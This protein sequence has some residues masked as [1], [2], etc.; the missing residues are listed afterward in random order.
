MGPN[1]CPCLLELISTFS[2]F[3]E[4]KETA[5]CFSG[6]QTL[7]H[8][9]C[10]NSV[11]LASDLRIWVQSLQFKF[12]ERCHGFREI[13]SPLPSFCVC[14]QN[15]WLSSHC[16]LNYLLSPTDG[17]LFYSPLSRQDPGMPS[18]PLY[19][20]GQAANCC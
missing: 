10:L 3:G 9:P 20:Q 18:S 15:A 13:T 5:M 12:L 17:F 6:L 8:F 7:P 4:Y 2:Q 16:S 14:F 11:I 1:S 19:T